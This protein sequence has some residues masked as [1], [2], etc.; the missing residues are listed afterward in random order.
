LIY[1]LYRLYFFFVIRHRLT[2]YRAQP[3]VRLYAPNA[4]GVVLWRTEEHFDMHAVNG[5]LPVGSASFTSVD[6][7]GWVRHVAANPNVDMEH[8][9]TA[10]GEVLRERRS[11][12]VNGQDET[13]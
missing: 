6:G 4:S 9:T 2:H 13:S 8:L 3:H 1:G 12:M 11:K 5:R 10:I 7:S